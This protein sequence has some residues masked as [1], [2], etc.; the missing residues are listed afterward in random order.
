MTG[1][2]LIF[3]CRGLDAFKVGQETL[4]NCPLDMDGRRVEVSVRVRI[5]SSENTPGGLSLCSALTLE[6]EEKTL[7]LARVISP[8]LGG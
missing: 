5:L 7:A 2:Q 6:D 8:N 3:R 4:V 1:A